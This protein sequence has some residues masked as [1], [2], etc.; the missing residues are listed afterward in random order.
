[1]DEPRSQ[2]R[3][4]VALDGRA[5]RV[6]AHPLRSRL[7]SAL[8]L[9]GPATATELAAELSSN[10]GATSYHLRAL[11]SVG[12][13]ADTGEGVGRRRVWRATSDAHSWAAADIAGDDARAGLDWLERDYVHRFAAR[14]EQWLDARDDW[15][16]EWQDAAGLGDDVLTVTATQA[17]ELARELGAVLDRYRALGEGEGEGDGDGALDAERVHVFYH[18]RPVAARPGEG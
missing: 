7:L 14:A 3:T 17:Q 15:P 10:T 5:V 16:E 9:G 4:V 6:L 8:R 12:L 1:M 13:V 11:E 18:L 2:P